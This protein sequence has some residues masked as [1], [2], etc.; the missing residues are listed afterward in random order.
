MSQTGQQLSSKGS[1]QELIKVVS[2][3]LEVTWQNTLNLRTQLE[4]CSTQVTPDNQGP[5][6]Q[7]EDEV[8]MIRSIRDMQNRIELINC[9][10]TDT[11]NRLA[12]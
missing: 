1:I 3:R 8:P 5:E 9:T 11:L 2:D 4:C 12:L 7:P 6:T 10:L